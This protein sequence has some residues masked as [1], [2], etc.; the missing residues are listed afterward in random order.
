M[1]Q[2]RHDLSNINVA[3]TYLERLSSDDVSRRYA[4]GEKYA[5]SVLN[6][7]KLIFGIDSTLSEL[8]N[9]Y[10]YQPIVKGTY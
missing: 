8:N 6:R 4:A 5:S 3:Y 9:F 1:T 7:L 2:Q 10:P